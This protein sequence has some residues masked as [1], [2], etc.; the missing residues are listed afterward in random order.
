MSLAGMGEPRFVDV[1]GIRMGYYEAGEGSAVVLMHGWPE[2][3]YSWRA[4]IPALAKAGYRAIA[5]DQ[6][7]FGITDCPPKV[8][9]Y[10]IANLSADLIGLLDALEIE[11]AIWCGHDWGALLAWQMPLLYPDRTAAV[12]GLNAPFVPR[13]PIEP[14]N[15]L[16]SAFGEM[17][18]VI[19]FQ[20]PGV[21]EGLLDQQVDRFFRTQMR[22]GG[23]TRAQYEALPR[24]VRNLDFL[25]PFREPEPESL[26]GDP[27]LSDEERAVFVEAFERTGFG[28]GINWYRNLTR[29][30]EAS[31]GVEQHSTAP[32]LMISGDED[33]VL[34]PSL[35]D[36]MEAYFP[37]LER[38]VIT[39]CGHWTQQEA[40]EEVNR[41]IIDWLDRRA[42][43]ADSSPASV[44]ERMLGAM[45]T[46][47]V[48]AIAACLAE[49]VT[50]E[51]MGADYMNTGPR[52]LGKAAVMDE[53]F[54][55][56]A[57][58]A[59]DWDHPFSFQPDHVTVGD[60]TVAVE[61]KIEATSAASG[62]PYSNIYC[63]V[64]EV[65]AGL[66][67]VVREYT[68]TEYAKRVLFSSTER[69]VG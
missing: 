41:L 67:K 21:V 19:Q 61:V 66:I 53:F 38:K 23:L 15:L 40:P 60:Q 49:D 34:P 24:E 51:V 22:A 64:Y 20:E 45:A 52:Y 54:A 62:D 31:L 10:D 65:E 68:N 16:R 43:F 18:Y 8:E 14:I 42:P 7:G 17:M 46:G 50:W 29:N 47:D 59:F 69:S 25:S 33:F 48:E 2:L 63:F 6:R 3:A 56:T 13:L 35:S 27:I 9:D 36:G 11:R 55:E 44:V 5:P 1:N 30:W 37:D 39:D 32:S 4:Q 28:P 58:P 57:V 12:I 26:P